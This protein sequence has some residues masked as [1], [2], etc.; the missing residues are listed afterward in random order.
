MPAGGEA[1]AIAF[2]EGVLGIAHVAKPPHLAARGGCWF[3]QGDLRIHVGVEA[4]FRPAKKAHP[5]LEVEGLAEVLH[6]LRAG[7]VPVTDAEPL[8]GIEHAYIE[9]PFGNRIELLE[10]T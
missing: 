5:A 4:D 10:Y 7:A 1:A 9:D 6:R 3:E 2:Y 8:D